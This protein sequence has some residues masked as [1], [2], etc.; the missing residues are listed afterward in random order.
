[1]HLPWLVRSALAAGLL[2]GGL[3]LGAQAADASY[4][5]GVKNQTLIIKGNRASDQLALR[6]RNNT[7]NKLDVDVNDDGSA[8]FK[9]LRSTFQ[10][11]RVQ[12]GGGN[13]T[14]RIDES[15]NR[16]TK[17]TPTRIDGERG[18]DTLT[19][20]GGGEK[21][22]GGPGNDVVD[23]NGGDDRADLGGGDDRFIWN[24]GDGN[25]DV[26][27][28]KGKDTLTFFGSNVNE[29][30]QISPDGSLARLTR[31][32][33]NIT[34]RLDRI[35]HVDVVSLGGDD[36]LTV[37]DLTGTRVR[38]VRN[39]LADVPDSVNPDAGA[40]TT[41]VNATDG[42]DAIVAKGSAGEARITGLAAKVDIAHA[43]A[44]D[45][46]LIINANAGD[47]TVSAQNLAAD[48]LRLTTDAGDDNDTVRGSA[49]ADITI[50]G[51]GN[52][53]VDGN[54]GNDTALLGGEDDRFIWDPG[55]GSD[56]IEGQA[57]RDTLTFNG[58]GVNEQFDASP[59]GSRV[60]FVRNVG[61]IVMDV[62]DL[63]EIDTNALGGADTLTVNDLSGTGVTDVKTDLAGTLGG[64]AGDGAADQV[65]VNATAGGD[66][67]NVSGSGGNATVSGLAATVGIAHAEAATDN[68]AIHALAGDDVVEAPGL[69]ADAI[70]LRVDGGDNNDV[71][72]GGSGN[73]TLNGG[74][75]DDVL[76]GGPGTDTL[77]GGTGNNTVI[78]D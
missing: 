11:I 56:T 51:Q 31:N 1:M 6:V 25:D 71:L 40:D 58:S 72:V 5:V 20:G 62:D 36:N 49:G 70:G 7:P 59:N 76:I 19:G 9:V 47:D 69:A 64:G 24:P 54:Q 37:D 22:N 18:N 78:Q 8:D 35:E 12:A 75:N 67:L 53:T 38:T 44:A 3:A 4:A 60:R 30:F 41:V 55:D 52:D 28:R 23:G 66:V 16:F 63:E 73:D 13:D 50:G 33:G 14:V 34:M 15:G 42:T 32:V 10:R 29:R 74:P 17:T 2:S 21:L 77:D 68:L 26:E 65:I 46:Q 39:D 27:G 43:A 57:G 61:N 48:A 45:D